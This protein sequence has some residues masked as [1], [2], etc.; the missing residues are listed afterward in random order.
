MEQTPSLAARIASARGQSPSEVPLTEF[1]AAAGTHV[2]LLT[3]L[4][5]RGPERRNGKMVQA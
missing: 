1:I 3:A 5:C 4:E 2:T